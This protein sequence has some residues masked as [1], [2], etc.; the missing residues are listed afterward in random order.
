MAF[1]GGANT[2]VL[3]E[4]L[5][6]S[7]SNSLFGE[8]VQIHSNIEGGLGIVGSQSAL[9]SYQKEYSEVAK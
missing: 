6:D 2:D 8:P 9:I 3:G 1:S 4:M 5:G 7:D